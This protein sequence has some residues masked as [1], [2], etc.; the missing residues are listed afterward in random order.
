MHDVQGTSTLSAG[1]DFP[2]S[3]PGLWPEPIVANLPDGSTFHSHNTSVW[4]HTAQDVADIYAENNVPIA[5]PDSP[6]AG[7]G[8]S[9]TLPAWVPVVITSGVLHSHCHTLDVVTRCS[10]KCVRGC[11]PCLALRKACGSW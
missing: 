4:C 2:R 7:T 11:L 6:N 1:A 10:G 9:T 5:E 3:A 8:D